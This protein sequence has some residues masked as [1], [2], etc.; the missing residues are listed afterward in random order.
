MN[1]KVNGNRHWEVGLNSG[2][3]GNICAAEGCGATGSVEK[4][5][6][7]AAPGSTFLSLVLPTPSA[8]KTVMPAL[9]APSY[10]LSEGLTLSSRDDGGSEEYKTHLFPFTSLKLHEEIA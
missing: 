6:Y 8:A 4:L 1:S 7:G 9:C 2:T 5:R 10:L 3:L